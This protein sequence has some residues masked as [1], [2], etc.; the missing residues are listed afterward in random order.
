VRN[1]EY[2]GCIVYYAFMDVNTKIK[3]VEVVLRRK[4]GKGERWKR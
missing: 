1:S 3:P 2:V 4:G